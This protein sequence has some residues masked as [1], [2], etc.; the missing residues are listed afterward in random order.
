[1]TLT[2][3]IYNSILDE[4]MHTN[5][6]YD[7]I[8]WKHITEDE[9]TD[10]NRT[11]YTLNNTSYSG[12]E[13][14][15]TNKQCVSEHGNVIYENMITSGEY[16][17]LNQEDQEKWEVVQ[18]FY[19]RRPIP[20]SEMEKILNKHLTDNAWNTLRV[21]RNKRIAETDYLATIDYPHFSEEAKQSWIDYRQALRDLPFTT[22][23]PANPVW[24]VPPE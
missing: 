21:E 19:S 17:A 5:D 15:Y 11:L 4:V 20:T 12:T 16:M 13:I 23:D 8:V 24:P 14:K 18:K 10:D 1:M 22:E 9:L 6:E 3:L 2:D 7:L